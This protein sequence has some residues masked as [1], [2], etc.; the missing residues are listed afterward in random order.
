MPTLLTSVPPHSQVFEIRQYFSQLKAVS[1]LH[2]IYSVWSMSSVLG[3]LSHTQGK[4]ELKPPIATLFYPFTKQR[5]SSQ[6]GARG[7]SSDSLFPHILGGGTG[8]GMPHEL[9]EPW[10]WP[11]GSWHHGYTQIHIHIQAAASRRWVGPVWINSPF[12]RA[13]VC[14]GYNEKVIRWESNRG[15]RQRHPI[16]A[17]VKGHE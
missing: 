3:L 6:T 11:W 8:V 10:V 9:G 15:P 4:Y 14:W 16:G 17:G 7:K 1:W 13:L 2:N 12:M 5:T